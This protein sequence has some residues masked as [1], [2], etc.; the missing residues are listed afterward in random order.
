MSCGGTALALPMVC[1]ASDR[2]GMLKI[3]RDSNGAKTTIRLIGRL[4]VN[5][6]E[7][8]TR[9]LQ[10]GAGQMVI[11]LQEVTLVDLDVVRFLVICEARGVTIENCAPY[12]RQWMIQEQSV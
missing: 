4:H 1:N 6:I 12:I 2:S 7:E 11:D 10:G 3:E 9:Q 8:L 5:H